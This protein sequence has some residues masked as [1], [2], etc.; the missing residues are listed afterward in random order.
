MK[1]IYIYIQIQLETEESKIKVGDFGT[2]FSM[3]SRTGGQNITRH[4]VNFTL[5]TNLT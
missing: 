3:I 2:P 4:I 1:Q 5:S